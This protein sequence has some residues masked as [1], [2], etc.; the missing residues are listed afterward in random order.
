MS[1]RADENEKK[2]KNKTPGVAQPQRRPGA[3][4]DDDAHPGQALSLRYR[5]STC[6]YRPLQLQALRGRGCCNFLIRICVNVQRR[7]CVGVGESLWGFRPKMW[8]YSCSRRVK[9]TWGNE[10]EG[11]R[12]G[13]LFFE[14]NARPR[15][16]L[17]MVSF[18][19]WRFY[20][21]AVEIKIKI[22]KG[23]GSHC[24]SVACFVPRD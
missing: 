19:A 17:V 11:E 24:S 3:I 18:C 15:D 5:G 4:F 12:R 1:C 23:F 20:S 2:K 10:I 9:E 8:T 7:P 14:Y 22:K 21:H 6:A 16:P 13:A